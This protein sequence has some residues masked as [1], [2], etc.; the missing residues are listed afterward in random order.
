MKKTISFLLPGSGYNPV[1]G[2]KVVYEYANR[3]VKDGY[4]VNVIYP[5]INFPEEKKL[6]LRIYSHLKKIYHTF[7]KKYSCKKWFNL[8]DK[9]REY[10]VYSLNEKNIPSSDFIIATSWET[11][12]YL[13]KYTTLDSVNKLYLIQHY[14][15]WS[16]DEIRLKKTWIAPLRKIVIAP[17]L[18]G[19]AEQLGKSSVLIENGL[20][21]EYFKLLEPI[22]E[23]NP[24]QLC[25]LYHEL[26][27]KGVNEGISAIEIVRKK[28]PDL[29]LDLFGVYDDPNLPDWV[30]YYK[31]PDKDVHIELYNKASIFVAPSHMEGFGLTAAEAMQCGCALACTDNGG[32]G[33]FCFHEKT[34]LVSPVKDINAL[35][36]NIIRLIEDKQ[37]RFRISKQG[38]EH[39][40]NFTW[41]SAYSKFKSLIAF[42]N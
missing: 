17:W 9:V 42:N 19:I 37:L 10:W 39:I 18:Q 6:R 8:D 21:F 23:R 3:F 13:D 27:W 33:V 11:A 16:E 40:Q 14:E 31:R 41:E 25:M 5:T 7:T 35:S 15:N 4:D 29:K 38:Y 12:E 28:Y 24:L 20:D 1:G 2:F 22:E 34:A 36:E 30:T 32:Y 26:E